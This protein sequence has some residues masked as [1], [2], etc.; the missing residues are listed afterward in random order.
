MESI[1][2]GSKDQVVSAVAREY[3]GRRNKISEVLTEDVRKNYVEKI[4]FFYNHRCTV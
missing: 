2:L 1:R 4:T 3:I